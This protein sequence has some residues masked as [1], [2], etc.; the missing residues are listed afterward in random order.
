MDGIHIY[1]DRSN[2]GVFTYL[3]RDSKPNFIDNAP[4]PPAGQSAVWAYKVIYV[5]NDEEVGL[6]SDVL[7]VTVSGWI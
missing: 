1:V 3:A 6:V 7:N 5:K 4:L 2:S